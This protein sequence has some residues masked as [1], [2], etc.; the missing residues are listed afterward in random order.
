MQ[1]FRSFFALMTLAIVL[2]LVAHA[3]VASDQQVLGPGLYVFQTRTV[4]ATCGDDERTGYVASFVAAVDGV[5]GAATM[6]MHVVDNQYWPSWNLTISAEGAVHAESFMDG[7]T[8]AGRPRSA[9]T[10][11][12]S[13]PQRFTGQGTRSYQ[14][15]V[16]GAART[17]TVTYDALLRRIDL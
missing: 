2:P 4:S 17:C 15:T 13:G 3:Q 12:R 1:V 14:A 7:T 6:H 10:V 16:D 11:T 8:G 5:P 9:F